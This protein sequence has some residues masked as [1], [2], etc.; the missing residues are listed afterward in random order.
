MKGDKLGMKKNNYIF[1]FEVII[2]II[3]LLYKLLF[4]IYFMIYIFYWFLFQINIF[5]WNEY[6]GY[7]ENLGL[8]W[9][10]NIKF[11]FIYMILLY[12]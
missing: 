1:E 2:N 11:K 6:K 7:D 9:L 4:L 5:I 3:Y 12:E 8:D 10:L